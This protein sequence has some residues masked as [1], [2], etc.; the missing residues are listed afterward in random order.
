[1]L[2]INV[3]INVGNS[4]QNILEYFKEDEVKIT[5]MES[6]LCKRKEGN[7]TTESYHPAYQ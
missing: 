1:M 5:Y 4:I 6:P 2:D 7:N 3:E